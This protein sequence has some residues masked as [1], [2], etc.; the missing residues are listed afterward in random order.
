MQSLWCTPRGQRE[1]GR[2]G[3]WVVG[4][5]GQKLSAASVGQRAWVSVIVVWPVV[6]VAVA[7]AGIGVKFT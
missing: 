6:A 5:V 1:E 4:F 2:Y 7:V 3:G